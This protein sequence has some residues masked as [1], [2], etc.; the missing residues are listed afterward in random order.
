MCTLNQQ[1]VISFYITHRLIQ[2]ILK[3]YYLSQVLRISWISSKKSDFLKHCESIKFCF[4]VR[5]YL[6]NWLLIAPETGKF[7]ILDNRDEKTSIIGFHFVLMYHHLLK[8]ISKTLTRPPIY[9][10]WIKNYSCVKKGVYSLVYFLNCEKVLVIWLGQSYTQRKDE[11]VPLILKVKYIY[12]Y[13][14]IYIY[15]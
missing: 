10:T 6:R 4:E 7:R 13:I 9:C 12:I 11:E 1:I 8:S 5:D 2:T 14:Y 15:Q 3:V